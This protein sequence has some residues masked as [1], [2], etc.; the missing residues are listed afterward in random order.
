MQR[1][2]DAKP[3]DTIGERVFESGS[4]FWFNVQTAQEGSLYLFAEGHDTTGPSEL[5]TLFPT[6]K[7]GGGVAR[8]AEGR[9]GPVT[10]APLKF[11][12]PSGIIYLWVIWA[13]RPVPLLDAI[14][15][16]SYDTGGSVSDAED[17]TK[18]RTLIEQHREPKPE[19]V[20]DDQRFRVTIRGRG[21]VLVDMRKLEYQP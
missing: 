15:R 16:R 12:G 10:G 8:L 20:A 18:L 17:Q 21:E 14:V 9:I 4:Q 11:R 2:R 1:P 13:E 19:V 6:P 5:N 3:F 7:S